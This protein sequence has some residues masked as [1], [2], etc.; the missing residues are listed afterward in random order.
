MLTQEE[1]NKLAEKLKIEA[2]P[3]RTD[4]GS[5]H[6]AGGREFR[7]AYVVD[8]EESVLVDSGYSKSRAHLFAAAPELYGALE[9][10]LEATRLLSDSAL[11]SADQLNWIPRNFKRAYEVAQFALAKARGEQPKEG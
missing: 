10:L 1:L 3:W 6:Y 5:P 9:M 2:L 8:A 7:Q 4:F 11:R